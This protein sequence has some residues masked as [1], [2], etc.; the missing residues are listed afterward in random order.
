MTAAAKPVDD[1]QELLKA[2]NAIAD[3]TETL[4]KAAP[5]AP[6][7]DDKMVAAASEDKDMPDKDMPDEDN[8]DEDEDKNPEDDD[9]GGE[10]FGKSVSFTDAAGVKHDAVDAT[11]MLKSLMERQVA[12]DGTLAKAL[13]SFTSVFSKQNELI[14]SLQDNIA[15][16]STQG[17]GR[18]TLLNVMEKPGVTDDLAKSA[19][20]DSGAIKPSDLLAKSEAAWKSG[21]LSGVEHATVDVCL[22][23][24]TP[25]DSSILQKIAGA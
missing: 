1:F 7:K 8:E 15:S 2:V 11:D 25:I 17:R 6:A 19:A 20:A 16:L 22:R 21:K 9:M 23:N 4:L 13:T 10:E 14:K 18:K 5:A 12:T 24:R 3:E